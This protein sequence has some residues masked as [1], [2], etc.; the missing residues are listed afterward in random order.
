MHAAEEIDPRPA[1]ARALGD[2]YAVALTPFP[3]RVG[4]GEELSEAVERRRGGDGQGGFD[5]IDIKIGHAASPRFRRSLLQPVSAFGVAVA[6]PDFLLPLPPEL[7]D[8]LV[9]HQAIGFVLKL[10]DF[11]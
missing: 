11:G 1:E 3:G 8:V 9:A 5:L 4:Q 7:I 6:D 10:L 2:L